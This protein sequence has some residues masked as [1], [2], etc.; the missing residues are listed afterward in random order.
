MKSNVARTELVEALFALNTEITARLFR[1]FQLD[2]YKEYGILVRPQPGD[3]GKKW[4]ELV[5]AIG[6]EANVQA[7]IAEFN[8][9]NEIAKQEGEP[10]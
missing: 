10:V 9:H 7:F 2:I 8:Q 5:E 6:P 3:T 4:V 1:G